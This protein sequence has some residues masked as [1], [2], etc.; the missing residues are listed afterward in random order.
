MGMPRD[1][2]CEVAL[3]MA[4]VMIGSQISGFVGEWSIVF[5]VLLI[6]AVYKIKKPKKIIIYILLSPEISP[7]N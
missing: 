7:K 3:I 5:G 6:I 4:A 1:V 2:L